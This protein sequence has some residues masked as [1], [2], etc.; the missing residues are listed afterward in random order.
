MRDAHYK[1]SALNG[2]GAERFSV[3][4]ESSLPDFV[5]SLPVLGDELSRLP[6]ET[7]AEFLSI[8]SSLQLYHEK[9]R[10]V[11]DLSSSAA[12]MLAG[13]DLSNTLE[14]ASS[15]LVNIGA[16]IRDAENGTE[17]RVERFNSVLSAAKEIEEKM[18]EFAGLSKGLRI[19]GLTTKIHAPSGGGG[20]RDNVLASNIK[21]LSEKINAR[22]VRSATDLKSVTAS[23]RVALGRIREI[24]D[25]KYQQMHA[26]LGKMSSGLR[27]LKK[28]HDASY[29]SFKELSV[30]SKQISE[31]IERVIMSAQFHD[32]TRQKFQHA[33]QSLD[34][35]CE[36]LVEGVGIN[37]EGD[38]MSFH[39]LQETAGVVCERLAVNLFEARDSYLG[40]VRSIM[41]SL[42]DI[43][44]GVSGLSSHTHSIVDSADITGRSFL[45]DIEESLAS[46]K[47][48]FTGVFEEEMEVAS[49][50]A[51]AGN[52]VLRISSL[53]SEI[54]EIGDNVEVIAMNAAVRS[55][56]SNGKGSAMGVLSGAIR[57][58]S[59]EST[60]TTVEATG[61]LKALSDEISGLLAA[62]NGEL[63]DTQQKAQDMEREM[64]ELFQALSEMNARV[65]AA[66]EE[67]DG[68][69]SDLSE[70][71]T[72]VVKGTKSHRRVEKVV[73]SVVSGLKALA[74]ESG[75]PLMLGNYS[76][77][78][79]PMTLAAVREKKYQVKDYP[80]ADSGAG[81]EFGDSIELF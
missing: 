28:K 58:V 47:A 35:L 48:A 25:S 40:A 38:A 62:V 22:A 32:I 30:V 78:R 26:T 5:R 24:K 65:A 29:G 18:E 45:H 66:L 77:D 64:G 12:S 50:V 36:I 76:L 1:K 4:D 3:A 56:Q 51:E 6:A 27:A 20:E 33:R 73:G 81:S 34:S 68:E 57:K 39:G 53:I 67:M 59:E 55:A 7:E 37:D 70:S 71:I 74:I 13:E 54:E 14:L 31:D 69:V 41:E 72:E 61:A 49:A 75:R 8:G 80:A 46:V 10:K 11:S 63:K 60:A 2:A 52:S 79:S 15:L 9:T 19:L 23:I 21:G 43:A 42:S 44:N 16:Y 17:L